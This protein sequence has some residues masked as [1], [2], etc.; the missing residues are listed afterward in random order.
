MSQTPES[1]T[2][3]GKPEV[4]G[5][6]RDVTHVLVGAFVVLGAIAL[7]LASFI[8]GAIVLGAALIV[9]VLATIGDI[10]LAVRRQKRL[11]GGPDSLS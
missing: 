5:T 1:R 3:T 2:K 8:S 4:P 11:G 7:G 9:L 10:V 6:P